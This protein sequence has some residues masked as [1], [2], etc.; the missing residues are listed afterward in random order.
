[1]SARPGPRP[2]VQAIIAP[3]DP[4]GT[5]VGLPWPPGMFTTLI[6][7]VTQGSK[8][9]A[10]TPTPSASN[11]SPGSPAPAPQGSERLPRRYVFP[12]TKAAQFVPKDVPKLFGSNPVSGYRGTVMIGDPLV[13]VTG[14]LPRES[15]RAGKTAPA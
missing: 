1:M 12:N 14:I 5:I 11:Q 4:S 3:P 13:I 7:S 15:T 2:S 10:E 9:P 6:P 8:G